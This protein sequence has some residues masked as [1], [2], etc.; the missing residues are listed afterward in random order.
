M[1]MIRVST[2]L[3]CATSAVLM[4]ACEEPTPPEPKLPVLEAVTPQ[5]SGVV[6][7]LTDMPPSIRVTRQSDGKPFPGVVIEFRLTSPLNGVLGATFDTTDALG[8]ATARTW[9]LGNTAGAKGMIAYAF[10]YGR[11]VGLTAIARAGPADRITPSVSTKQY[12][13]SSRDPF[14]PVVQVADKYGNAVSGFSVNFVVGA[15]G[16]T[17]GTT[18]VVTNA[19]GTAPATFWKI[20]ATPGTYTVSAMAGFPA[21]TFSAQR[22]DSTSLVWF[23]LDSLSQSGKTRLLSEWGITTARLGLSSFDPCLCVNGDGHY[24]ERV[25]YTTSNY[26]ASGGFHISGGKALLQNGESLS[27][28]GNTLRVTRTDYYYY[29]SPTTWIY[30]R[31]N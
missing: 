25:D 31:R 21:V 29:S 24:F 6:G 20:P 27:V 10:S 17:I 15:E 14:P 8:I 23:G 12:V 7:E 1:T 26:E 4:G 18:T 5:M 13:M 16:G 9:R 28:V 2:Y 11:S 3:L 22:V 19:F 30:S